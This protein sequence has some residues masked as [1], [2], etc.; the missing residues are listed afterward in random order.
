ML[1]TVAIATVDA[2]TIPSQQQRFSEADAGNQLVSETRWYVTLPVGTD[3][4]AADTYEIGGTVYAITEVNR[5]EMWPTA[6]R[7]NVSS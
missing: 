3:V 2:R 7:C 1:G 6:V 4:T 5:G